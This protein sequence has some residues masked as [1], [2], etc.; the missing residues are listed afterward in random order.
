MATASEILTKWQLL[1][2]YLNRRQRTLWAA[3]EAAAIGYGGI[4]LLQRLTGL[5]TPAVSAGVV[6][7]RST[8]GSMAGTLVPSGGSP[9]AGRR[10]TE[11]N[12]PQLEQD[13]QAMLAEEVAGDPMCGQK[14]I[15]SSLR[16]LSKRLD[17]QGHKA[18]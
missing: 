9:F 11:V 1:S 17:R 4:A 2:P 6:K 14:W 12:D 18:C 7:L 15:R 10:P 5:S 13:L 16:N 3:A 8:K